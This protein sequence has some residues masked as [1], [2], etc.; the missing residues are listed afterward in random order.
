M[1]YVDRDRAQRPAAFDTVT[2]EGMVAAARA[3]FTDP[4]RSADTS[5]ARHPVRFSEYPFREDISAQLLSLFHGKCAYCEREL[6]GLTREVI[7]D[8]FA[9]IEEVG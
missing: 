8:F 1:L 4:A 9:K 7:D 3:I 2:M 6:D 5:Q